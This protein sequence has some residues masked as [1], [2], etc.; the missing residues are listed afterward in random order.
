MFESEFRG[1]GLVSQND[2]GDKANFICFFFFF[3][4][5]NDNTYE[6]FKYKNLKYL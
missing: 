5:K 2:Y 4:I 3:N 1:P 6:I